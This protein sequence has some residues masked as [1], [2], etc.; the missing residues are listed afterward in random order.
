MSVAEAMLVMLAAN[1]NVHWT[2]M[3]R[4]SG[5]QRPDKALTHEAYLVL[6]PLLAPINHLVFGQVCVACMSIV[7]RHRTVL[8]VARISCNCALLPT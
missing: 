1:A 8:R 4:D 6:G 3:P 7:I 5:C 2:K